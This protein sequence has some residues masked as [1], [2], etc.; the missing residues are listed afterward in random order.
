M[1]PL[2]VL[3]VQTRTPPNEV[4][5]LPTGP[6]SSERVAARVERDATRV[7]PA[8]RGCRLNASSPSRT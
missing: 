5:V 8:R 1:V 4:E 6:L 7:R 3:P 2:T